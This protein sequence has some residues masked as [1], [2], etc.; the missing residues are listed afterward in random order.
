M[1]LRSSLKNT[2]LLLSAGIAVFTAAF[3]ATELSL[4]L[5]NHHPPGE[6]ALVCVGSLL[7]G[8]PLF[9]CRRFPTGV[10][11]TTVVS[12]VLL[13]TVSASPLPPLGI[14]PALTAL[15]ALVPP[16]RSLIAA[17]I[18]GVAV[19]WSWIEF[20]APSPIQ[21]EGLAYRV[22]LLCTVVVCAWLLGEAY[23]SRRLWVTLAEDN[24]A[25]VEYART[26]E[27]HRA[28]SEERERISR[29]MHDVLAHNVSLMVVQAT[30]ANSVVHTQ[31]D[32]AQRAISSIGEV[33]RSALVELRRMLGCGPRATDGPVPQPGLSQLDAL[34]NRVRETGLRV[35][36]VEDGKRFELPPGMDL[37]VYRIIQEALTNVVRH[38][39]ANNIEVEFQW[40]EA[41]LRITVTDDGG[42]AIEPLALGRGLLG[43]NERVVLLG[44]SL[45]T[46]SNPSGKGFRVNVDLPKAMA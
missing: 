24:A 25:R 7:Q 9:F 15:A 28:T 5:K 41:S 39:N 44:G 11:A 42:S 13:D 3:L 16:P 36:M 6:I 8:V 46:G 17:A 22:A 23:R 38:A 20:Q 29:E 14:F 2:D 33:G 34:L 37:S 43:M 30:A 10:L 32:Q 27:I 1:S 35:N 45:T 12:G 40:L 26:L 21:P 18:A 4:L 19:V 31:P